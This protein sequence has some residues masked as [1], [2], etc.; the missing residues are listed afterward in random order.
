MK[1]GNIETKSNVFLAPMAGWTDY[2]YRVLCNMCGAGLVVTEMVSSLGL[3]YNSKNTEQL[4]ITCPQEKPVAVQI[5][6]SNPQ[7]MAEACKNEKLQNFDIIDINMGCPVPKVVKNG[8]GSALMKNLP[9]ASQIISECK[10]ATT[11]PV[12]VKFRLGFENNNHNVKEFAKMCQ[13]SGADAV[14]IHGRTRA[15]FYAGSAVLDEIFEVAELIDIPVIANGDISTKEDYDKIMTQSK[16]AGVAIGRASIGNPEIFS[17]ILGLTSNYTKKELILKHRDLLTQNYSE[18]YALT[19]LKKNLVFYINNITNATF[20]RSQIFQ[21]QSINE[22][23]N[24]VFEA[25]QIKDK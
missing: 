22:V 21:S 11:K 16:C 4:L 17:Q 14:T 23:L 24:V 1:I 20:Y 2:P 5:F 9:L 19:A 25:L 6:G 12:T 18:K 8:E 13:D 10:K 3:H 15:Q 7:V